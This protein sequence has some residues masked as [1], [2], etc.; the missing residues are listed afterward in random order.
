MGEHQVQDDITGEQLRLFMRN[1]L[2][3]LRALARMIE[4]GWIESGVRRIGAEQEMFLVGAGWRPAPIATEVLD[5]ID[6]PH[7]TTELAR[8]NLEANLDPLTFGGDCLS[9]MEAQL[10]ELL[11]KASKG[12]RGV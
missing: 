10:Q 12:G 4:D 5:V 3:D 9:K 2:D 11:G 1:L 6:D 7:F 8:F